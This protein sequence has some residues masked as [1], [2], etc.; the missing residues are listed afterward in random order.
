MKRN[1]N[2]NQRIRSALFGLALTAST[3]LGLAADITYSF[4][5]DVQGWY[6]AEA[7]GSVAWDG[8]KGRGGLGC[9]KYT[10]VA[11]TDTEVDPRVDVAYDTSGYF[12]VEFDMMVDPSSGTGSGGYGNMQIIARDA[13]YSWNSMW[14]GSLGAAGGPFSTW[15]HVKRA[16]TSAFGLKAFLQIQISPGAI[17]GSDI[18]V[19]IDNVVIRD[20]TPP[21]KAVLYDYA[22]PEEVTTGLSSWG[23]GIVV[24]HDTTVATN[25]SLKF[26]AT[27]PG[28]G[29]W[30]EAVVQT[31]PFDW[32]PSKFT[33]IDFDLYLDAP[34]GLPSYGALQVFQISSSWGWTGIANPG[35]SEAKNVG[36]WAHY[37][38]ALNSMS[39]SHGLVFQANGGFASPATFTYYLDNVEIWKP[40]TPPTIRALKQETSSGGAKITMD[41]SSSGYQRDAICVPSGNTFYTWYGQT[42]ISYSFTITNFPDAVAHPGF[43]AHLY[44]V[45]ESSIPA[46][47]QWNET[48]GGCDWNAA[49]II[50][51]R[52]ENAVAG[53]VIARIDWK[54]NLPGAN[55]LTNEL[56][57]PVSVQGPSALGTWTLTFNDNTSA[58]V[59]GPGITAT[60]FTLPAE[61]AAR[62]DPNTYP[63]SFVQ[64]GVFKNDGGTG[65]NNNA[66]GTFSEIGMNGGLYPFA[67]TFPGPGLQGSGTAWR[68]SSST[69]VQ[70]VPADTAWWLT[71]STP[72]DGYSV[73]VSGNVNGPYNDAGVTYTYPSGATKVGAIPAASMPAGRAA[74]F[75]LVK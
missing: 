53:G 23:S 32:A 34:A 13:A 30:Q 44:I 50:E 17:T 73:Q 54:T 7:H 18:I 16:F 64:F 3:S 5:S 47:G 43:E 59:T 29:G 67:E 75:R 48:Y 1:R 33:Y 70:W 2:L 10:I 11:G 27:Y 71:W 15:R 49:D 51:L 68:T 62:F 28:G 74:F 24:S 40:A 56:Y 65:K 69:A 20:G 31:T 45:N 19:Y 58:T 26:V 55:P 52:V 63:A 41:Q 12:S 21:T 4:D 42:P 6:A 25:G 72:D 38:I 60:N 61:A 22:W 46:S 8:T 37:S 66:S 9:L 36:K 14:Y 57:H 35:L 39:L